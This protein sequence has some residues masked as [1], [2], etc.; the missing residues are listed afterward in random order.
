LRQN[1]EKIA[2]ESGQRNNT[3]STVMAISQ[4]VFSVRPKTNFIKYAILR[5][6]NYIANII[7]AA[8]KFQVKL[9]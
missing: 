7:N 8:N 3:E 9:L 5:A 2:S 4:P 1:I 6:A